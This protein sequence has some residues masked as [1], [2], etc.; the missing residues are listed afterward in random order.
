MH[1]STFL[2]E[3]SKVFNDHPSLSVMTFVPID[4]DLDPRTIGFQTRCLPSCE[5]SHIRGVR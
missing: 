3:L 4:K 1:L 5:R 2:A